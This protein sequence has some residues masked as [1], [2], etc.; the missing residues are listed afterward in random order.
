MSVSRI[1][2]DNRDSIRTA[3]SVSRSGR[4]HRGA[5]LGAFGV[6]ETVRVPRRGGI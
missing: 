5:A 2:P 6:A 4:S 1:S 3:A